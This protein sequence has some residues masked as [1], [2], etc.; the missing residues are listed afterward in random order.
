MSKIY[1]T[2]SFRRWAPARS[3][4]W[5]RG[6]GPWQGGQTVNRTP[7]GGSGRASFPHLLAFGTQNRNYVSFQDAFWLMNKIQNKVQ[8]PLERAS[9]WL[10]SHGT[11]YPVTVARPYH[12]I[13]S[14]HYIVSTINLQK[15]FHPSHNHI[16]TGVLHE[17]VTQ[18]VILMGHFS[19]GAGP[20]RLF[21]QSIKAAHFSWK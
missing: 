16:G 15:W 1:V 10:A 4:C 7:S 21:R 5:V 3:L 11:L 18:T 19:H 6:S 13:S 17:V 2:L 14:W 20:D 9:C 8:L 12:T